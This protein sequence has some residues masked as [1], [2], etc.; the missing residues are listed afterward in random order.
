MLET[1]ALYELPLS[2]RE[3]EAEIVELVKMVSILLL[4]LAAIIPKN[5]KNCHSTIA[6]CGNEKNISRYQCQAP[7]LAGYTLRIR[8]EC[9]RGADKMMVG[10]E[11]ISLDRDH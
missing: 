11:R 7:I 2:E 8:S 3:Q 9:V 1:M 4:S 5:G 6:A 10:E